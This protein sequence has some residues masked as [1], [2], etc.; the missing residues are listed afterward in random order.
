M[1]PA[2]EYPFPELP[3]PGTGLEVAAGVEW[4]RMP[5]PFAI[6][7]INLWLLADGEA[8]TAVDSGFASDE[9]K[10]AWK[11]VLVARRLARCV[12]T[13]GHPDHI[14]LAAWLEAEFGAPLWMS[15]GDYNF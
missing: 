2:L 6:D 5:L 4:L 10:A 12:V 9:T 14:G 13:H 15:Q 1:T 8:Y 7:H 3:A 11:S